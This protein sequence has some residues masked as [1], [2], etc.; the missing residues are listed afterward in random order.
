[1]IS[2]NLSPCNKNIKGLIHE[3]W[4]AMPCL[5]IVKSINSKES[6]MIRI[7]VSV[8]FVCVLAIF[9]CS[10]GEK[11]TAEADAVQ[12]SGKVTAETATS[13]SSED[14][15]ADADDDDDAGD[16]DTGSESDESDE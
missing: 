7:L 4:I 2:A 5:L 12:P 9:G 11:N 1:M 10:F 15:D 14:A 13:D 16:D 3:I 6:T 8:V